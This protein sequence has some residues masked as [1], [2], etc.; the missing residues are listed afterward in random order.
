MAGALYGNLGAHFREL[1]MIAPLWRAACKWYAN[2]DFWELADFAIQR[3]P[4]VIAG[5]LAD[6]S[7]IDRI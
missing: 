7:V 3:Q 6:N 1:M 5:A 2:M 4:K